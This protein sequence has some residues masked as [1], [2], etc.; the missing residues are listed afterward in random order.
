MESSLRLEPAAQILKYEDIAIGDEFV[1]ARAFLQWLVI[2][3]N[4]IGR[5]HNQNRQEVGLAK[6]GENYG[7]QVHPVAHGNHNLGA[8]K[9]RWNRSPLISQ[10][11]KNNQGQR[12]SDQA[13]RVLRHL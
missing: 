10:G 12:Q 5:A 13:Q 7:L 4:P 2:V 6:G 8:R 1:E 3:R 9:F 11:S